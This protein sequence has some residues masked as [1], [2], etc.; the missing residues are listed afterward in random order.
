M[1]FDDFFEHGHKHDKHNHDHHY[2][3]D[4]YYQKSHSS[5]DHQDITRVILSKLSTNPK[6]KV[7]LIIAAIIIIVV[8]VIFVILL[9]PL[10]LK[11]F[12]FI[13][14]NGIQGLIDAIWSGTK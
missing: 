13:S 9:F 11:F 5:H 14:E 10:L 2:G 12:R 8:V 7:L 1:G 6:L 4:E 3:H